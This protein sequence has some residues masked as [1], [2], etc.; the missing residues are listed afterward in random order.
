MRLRQLV[1]RSVGVILLP[2]KF[3][4]VA[5]GRNQTQQPAAVVTSLRAAPGMLVEN[6]RRLADGEPLLNR[7][8]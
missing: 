2:D 4:Q 7:V 5:A 8:V 6:C 3:R 1:T